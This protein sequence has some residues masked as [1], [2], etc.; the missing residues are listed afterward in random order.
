[1]STRQRMVLKPAS[2]PQ[3]APEAGPVPRVLEWVWRLVGPVAAAP[4]RGPRVEPAR[5]GFGAPMTVC[6]QPPAIGLS[7][8]APP[9]ARARFPAPRQGPPYSL[10][11]A[12]VRTRARL[13]LL[14]L[15]RPRRRRRPLARRP[16]APRRSS[17]PPA[18]SPWSP[19]QVR[20]TARAVRSSSPQPPQAALSPAA[21]LRAALSPAALSPAALRP[22]APRWRVTQ[23]QA[24][25][26]RVARLPVAPSWVPALRS[27]PQ[28]RARDW[29]A[30]APASIRMELARLA[31]LA[32]WSRRRRKPR[33]ATPAS[34]ARSGAR[35]ARY[36]FASALRRRAA[37][38]AARS[39]A[40]TVLWEQSGS[41]PAPLRR[42]RG[43]APSAPRMGQVSA[44]ALPAS[45]WFRPPVTPALH[46]PAGW[47]APRRARSSSGGQ[48]W[49]PL[50]ASP[51]GPPSPAVPAPP[52]PVPH[53]F[54]RQV[55]PARFRRRRQPAWSRLWLLPALIRQQLRRAWTRRS[56]SAHHP[57]LHLS[58]PRLMLRPLLA[59]GTP[60]LSA[61]RR[62]P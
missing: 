1:M 10:A 62:Q 15:R 27:C 60:A 9:P 5:R 59:A 39:A 19:P 18:G 28:R 46:Q 29:A 44:S 34:C 13:A 57:R 14:V 35:G 43:L 61:D 40:Q 26:W 42:P 22:R 52:R 8:P 51:E 2:P 25:R 38:S 53:R 54:R 24:A 47:S 21:P 31:D 17:R 45:A 55:P 32:A 48:A 49:A 11:E 58:R 12:P 41:V 33:A 7:P 20:A 4:G 37:P 23:P 16:I 50:R 56:L 3:P 6:R 30:R 36:R